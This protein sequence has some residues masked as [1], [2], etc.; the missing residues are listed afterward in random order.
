MIQDFVPQGYEFWYEVS[1]E[2]IPY[3]TLK[4]TGFTIFVSPHVRER[5]I[6]ANH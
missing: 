1:R 3:F 5:I 4:N 6:E 2:K